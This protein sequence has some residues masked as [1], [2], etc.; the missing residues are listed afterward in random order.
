MKYGF[1]EA[2]AKAFKQHTR[3]GDP[4]DIHAHADGHGARDQDEVLHERSLN[5]QRHTLRV[6]GLQGPLSQFIYRWKMPAGPTMRSR[7]EGRQRTWSAPNP[8]GW[9]MQGYAAE[10]V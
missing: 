8:G 7:E 1:G 3:S 4:N 6:R 2:A 10:R 5:H 9:G